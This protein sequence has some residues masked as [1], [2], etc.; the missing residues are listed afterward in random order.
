MPD[1]AG[2][3]IKLLYEQNMKQRLHE[4]NVAQGQEITA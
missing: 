4:L 2:I 3:S 1:G